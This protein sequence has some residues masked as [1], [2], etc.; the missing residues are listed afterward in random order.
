MTTVPANQRLDLLVEIADLERKAGRNDAA[1][2]ALARAAETASET[3][4]G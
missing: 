1:L 3:T 2:A 4:P